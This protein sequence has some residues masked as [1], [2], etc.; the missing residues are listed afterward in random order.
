M[1]DLP[2]FDEA[3]RRKAVTLAVALTA[4]TPLAPKRYERELL[5][6]FQAGE[7]TIDQVLKL[8]DESIYQVL[9]RSQANRALVDNELND[10][11]TRSRTFNGQHQITGLL[12]Y[13]NGQFV[14]VIE[15]PEVEVRALYARIQ[16]DARHTQVV[17]ISDGPGPQRWFADWRMAFGEV[18]T[19]ELDQVL[20][21]YLTWTHPS[22]LAFPNRL[23]LYAR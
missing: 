1:A 16:Q 17:T 10:L 2:F 9:Y 4:D 13:S 15:G 18:D 19:L 6:R 14:Q 11:L 3:A 8:L 12:L 22:I 23:R 5:A 21:A 20:G 7:V